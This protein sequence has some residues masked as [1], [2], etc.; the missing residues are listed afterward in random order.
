MRKEYYF[1]E[2][3]LELDRKIICELGQIFQKGLF[4]TNMNR[5]IKV[6]VYSGE[7][8][9][10]HFHVK[11]DQR[12][13]NAKF[14]INPFEL[15]ENKTSVSIDRDINFIVRYFEKNEDLLRKIKDRFIQ[16]NPELEYDKK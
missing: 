6:F 4:P 9:P 5:G 13:L 10:I 12:Y 16:L 11:S 8:L 2:L 7:H 15:L 14:S 1:E 3:S